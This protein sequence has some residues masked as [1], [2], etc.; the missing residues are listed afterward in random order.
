M[1]P[2]KSSLNFNVAPHSTF[3][4]LPRTNSSMGIFKYSEIS[5]K[6]FQRRSLSKS[7]PADDLLKA[8][9]R[10]LLVMVTIVPFSVMTILISKQANFLFSS[11]EVMRDLYNNPQKPIP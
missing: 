6:Q 11:A 5:A 7:P 4:N 2:P 3:V 8:H 1:K 9:F 10:R